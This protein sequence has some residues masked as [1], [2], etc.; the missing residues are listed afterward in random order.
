MKYLKNSLKNTVYI[1]AFVFSGIQNEVKSLNIIYILK[2]II[3]HY[4]YKTLSLNNFKKSHNLNKILNTLNKIHSVS[5][6]R[7]QQ[8][9]TLYYSYRVLM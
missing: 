9:N 8:K 6:E 1:T 4:S 7:K 2:Y 5:Y 3:D